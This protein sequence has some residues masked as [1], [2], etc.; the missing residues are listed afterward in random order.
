M[1]IDTKTDN[2]KTL[3]DKNLTPMPNSGGTVI[4]NAETYKPAARVESAIPSE[5]HETVTMR[6]SSM[7]QIVAGLVLFVIVAS[8]AGLFF[9]TDIFDAPPTTIDLPANFSLVETDDYRIG[10]PRSMLPAVAD[11]IDESTANRILHRWQN[12]DDTYVSLALVNASR[13]TQNGYYTTYYEDFIT[14]NETWRFIDE[15]TFEDGT[16]RQ[17]Y[18]VVGD[19]SLDNGQ[20]DVFYITRDESL[21]VIENVYI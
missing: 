8:G 13:V 10:I 17:S 15:T 6:K 19:S 18:R 16:L 21:V 2:Q 3:V 5:K 20:I 11:F 14:N 1:G 4:A 9:L 12:T 7:M